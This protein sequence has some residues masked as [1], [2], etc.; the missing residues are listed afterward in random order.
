MRASA[1]VLASA[2]GLVGCGDTQ[3]HGGGVQ[4]D[5]SVPNMGGTV[6]DM[7]KPAAKCNPM[8]TLGDGKPCG[9]N[10]ACPGGQTPVTIKGA[11]VCLTNCD[12]SHQAQCP[13]DRF[14]STVGA[15]VPDGGTLGG[16]CLPANGPGERCGNDPA[17]NPYGNGI[18][19]QGT[20]CFSSDTGGLSQG[21]QRYCFYICFG[22]NSTCPQQ[23]ACDTQMGSMPFNAC[24]I[25]HQPMGKALG[26]AC[27]IGTDVCALGGVCDGT[28]CKPQCDGPKGTCASG[29]CTAVNDGMRIVGYVC[30]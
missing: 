15:I 3:E 17:G 22:Q 29:T 18:C 24:D 9:A 28:T 20:A 2:L 30:K 1:I 4:Q 23:T 6:P 5:M 11:C 25:Q 21:T 10:A 7:A 13:C 16:A 8:D 19:E 12:P 14:C 26:A 27:T